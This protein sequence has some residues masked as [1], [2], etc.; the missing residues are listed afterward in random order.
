MSR[1]GKV[2]GIESV[3]RVVSRGRLRW[4]EHLKR[5]NADDWVSKCRKLEVVGGIRKGRDKK[6]WMQCVTTDMKRTGL[7]E[8][9]RRVGHYGVV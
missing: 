8:R 9:M 7:K 5:K 3:E 4:Y 1:S 6:T 2:Y